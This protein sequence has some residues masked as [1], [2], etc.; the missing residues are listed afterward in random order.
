LKT[1]ANEELGNT[2]ASWILTVT[3][4]DGLYH[5]RRKIWQQSQLASLPA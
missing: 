5:S 3:I 1:C 4:T 2:V